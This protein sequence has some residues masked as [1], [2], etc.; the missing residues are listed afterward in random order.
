MSNKNIW[1]GVL[2]LVAVAVLVGLLFKGDRAGGDVTIESRY[3]EKIVYTTNTEQDEDPF[4]Q[5]CTGEGGRFNACGSPCEPGAEFCIQVCAFTCDLSG[6][7][8][9]SVNGETDNS[10]TLTL[11][12]GESATV[13]GL[14]VRP[15][16]VTE[17]S[18]CPKDVYCIQTG[19]ISIETELATGSATSTETLTLGADAR[20]LGDYNV[21]VTGVFPERESGQE[22]TPAAYKI[23]YTVTRQ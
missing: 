12:L 19:R 5:N 3:D 18:R 22:L 7:N 8:Q 14:R 11:G 13:L 23:T 16:R 20:S 2:A 21:S 9:N 6:G 4:R 15:L 1:F 10:Q 17:D